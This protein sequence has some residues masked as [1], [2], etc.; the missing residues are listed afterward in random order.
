MAYDHLVRFVE[1]PIFTERIVVALDDVSY[2]KLQVALILSVPSH[3]LSD[4]HPIGFGLST[5]HRIPSDSDSTTG[6]HLI[7]LGL[8][9]LDS[10]SQ[11]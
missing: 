2:R 4:V 5:G 11:V 10:P 1:T 8:A 7:G 6:L 9:S 3:T